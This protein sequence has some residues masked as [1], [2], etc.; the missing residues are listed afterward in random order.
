MA[1]I[2]TSERTALAT[3]SRTLRIGRSTDTARGTS[4][5][6]RPA[7]GPS[8]RPSPTY[9][10][11]GRPIV[12]TTPSGSRRKILISSQ[13]SFHRPRS[14]MSSL[15]VSNLMTGELQKHVLECRK[16]RPEVDD[17]DPVLAQAMDHVR[18]QVVAAAAHREPGSLAAH[19]VHLRHRLKA[20]AGRGVL[21]DD[22]DASLG[23]M[24]AHQRR[25]RSNIDDAAVVD[26]GDAVAQALGLLHQ[27]RRQEHGFAAI[28]DAAD[29][30][31]DRA[32]RLRVEA[33]R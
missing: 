11:T 14:T 4:G 16:L 10:S 1:M 22:D 20:V 24:P 2:A 17:A 33:G 6:V 8:S 13:V 28:A 15:S 3:I 18:H 29:E 5:D 23:A 27:V 9:T 26:D 30:I 19:R 12:P 32:A 31:P 25:W 21:G 7:R